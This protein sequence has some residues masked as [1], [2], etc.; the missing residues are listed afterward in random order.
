MF[1]RSVAYF[2]VNL[3]VFITLCLICFSLLHGNST[4][5]CLIEITYWG[6]LGRPLLTSQSN[7]CRQILM[8]K[9]SMRERD[10]SHWAQLFPRNSN[11]I[12]AASRAKPM[13]PLSPSIGVPL[14]PRHCPLCALQPGTTYR[15]SPWLRDLLW[16]AS[17]HVTVN[18][19]RLYSMDNPT[20]GFGDVVVYSH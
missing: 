3:C 20:G 4:I 10:L 14:S 13:V 7:L 1:S 18:A 15:L 5:S 11:W 9:R 12:P 16:T 19:A 17:P 2:L 6:L 8:E